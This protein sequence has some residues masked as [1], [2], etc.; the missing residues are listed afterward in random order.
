[1]ALFRYRLPYRMRC[2]TSQL[3]CRRTLV[4]NQYV[5]I[6]N[7]WKFFANFLPPQQLSLLHGVENGKKHLTTWSKIPTSEKR[8]VVP[9][10]GGLPTIT[11][12]TTVLTLAEL[13]YVHAAPQVC[14]YIYY[15]FLPTFKIHYDKECGTQIGSRTSFMSPVQ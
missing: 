12:M 2:A 15:H 3:A 10:T 8:L 11:P 13:I 1:M 7:T 5:A 14:A 4:Q 9:W 6:H